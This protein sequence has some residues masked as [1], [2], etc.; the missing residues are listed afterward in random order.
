[1]LEISCKDD[2]LFNGLIETQNVYKN[3]VYDFTFEKRFIIYHA[4]VKH[5]CEYYA[6]DKKT[7]HSSTVTFVNKPYEINKE[8]QSKQKIFKNICKLTQKSDSVG[9]VCR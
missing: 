3:G 8:T 2:E 1:M 9:Y 4:D 7:G 6:Y 5:G